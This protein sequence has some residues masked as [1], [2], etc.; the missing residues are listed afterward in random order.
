[1]PNTTYILM[2]RKQNLMDSLDRLADSVAN[3]STPGYKE[4]KDIFRALVVKTEPG[5]EAYG[6]DFPVVVKTQ[7]NF[8]QGVMQQ[9]FRPLDFAI[10][11]DAFFTVT[12]PLGPR[13]TKAGNFTLDGD[14]ILVT[15]EG[16]TVA[17]AGG[18]EIAFAPEDSNITVRE[19]GT[20]E[21]S[22]LQRG[23]MAIASFSDKDVLIRTGTGFYRTEEAPQPRDAGARVIQG[24]IESSNVSAITETV[25]LTQ[26]SNA[27]DNV[28]KMEST[29]HDT[30]M[31]MIRKIG[32]T[33]R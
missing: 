5:A 24:Y 28:K 1:M 19:D 25:H 27:I 17:S 4:E 21:S 3:A 23:T 13:Y 29:H 31:G 12:T 22:G 18:G 2:A 11:G 26:I 20:I 14:G 6:Q 7:R 16:Y 33:S 15:K 9:T 10:E 32:D 30:L 8:E